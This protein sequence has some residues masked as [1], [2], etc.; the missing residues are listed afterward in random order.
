MD[1]A[2]IEYYI[3]D[4]FRKTGIKPFKPEFVLSY[5]C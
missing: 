2:F 3:M 5:L 1:A 4:N